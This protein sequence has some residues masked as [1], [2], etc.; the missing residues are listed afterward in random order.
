MFP[1]IE[2]DRKKC[3]T[4]YDCKIC[5]QICPTAVF[6]VVPTKIDRFKE[7]DPENY[8]VVAVFRDKCVACMQCVKTCPQK[9]IKIEV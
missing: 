9:A 3:I 4:P 5:L 8:E 7:T 6:V 2:I 1:K